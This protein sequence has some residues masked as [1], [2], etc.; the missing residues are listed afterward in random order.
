[1][2]SKSDSTKPSELVD[3]PELTDASSILIEAYKGKQVEATARFQTHSI[4]MAAKGYRP[5]W[6][7]WAPGEWARE[8][9]VVAVLLIFLF[10]M[11]ILYLG[12]LL[13]VEP[14]GTLT[15]ERRTAAS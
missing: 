14:E 5:T 10:G 11:G 4:E 2:A 3:T 9:Y 6:Q 7:S 12:Y 8:A 13:I 15:Y 1:M